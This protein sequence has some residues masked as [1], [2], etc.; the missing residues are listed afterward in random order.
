MY[1]V[2]EYI[3]V[4]RRT[5]WLKFVRLRFLSS[6]AGILILINPRHGNHADCE[7]RVELRVE[8][9]SVNISKGDR[10]LR[11]YLADETDC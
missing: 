6:P 2:S 7:R 10:C 4:C 5:V 3:D 11:M 9:S 1:V 8:E